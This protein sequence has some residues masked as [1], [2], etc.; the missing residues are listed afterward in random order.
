M[1]RR[2]SSAEPLRPAPSNRRWA[3]FELSLAQL[4]GAFEDGDI[5]ILARHDANIF[6]QFMRDGRHTFGEAAG[7]QYIDPPIFLL[8]QRAF[9]AAKRLGW[10]APSDSV[11]DREDLDDETCDDAPYEGSPN[12]HRMWTRPSAKRLAALAVCTFQQVYGVTTLDT[13]CYSSFMREGGEQVRWPTLGIAHYDTV[14][15]RN[16]S[17]PDLDEREDGDDAF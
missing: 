3:Q 2:R 9:A 4:F 6:V 7:N 17:I 1:P 12:F 15:Y 10:H 13:L 14:R 8:D 5:L 16:L 11:H